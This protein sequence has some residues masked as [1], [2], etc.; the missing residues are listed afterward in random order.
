MDDLGLGA[1]GQAFYQAVVGDSVPNPAQQ[2]LIVEGARMADRLEALNDIIRGKGVLELMHFRVR[3]AVDDS[4]VVS[5][6]LSVDSVLSECRQLQLA[7]ER[8]AKSLN[9]SVGAIPA[10]QPKGDVS[11]D[12][13]AKRAA[14][15]SA[16]GS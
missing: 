8:V 12:L 9:V 5:V 10:A 11:D 2:A 6:E 4:G 3:H 1:R 14:R 15:R 7:F 13:A 16:A